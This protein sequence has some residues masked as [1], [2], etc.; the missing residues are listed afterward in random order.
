MI[1]CCSGQLAWS[2]SDLSRKFELE[3]EKGVPNESAEKE[4][5]ENILFVFVQH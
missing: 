3:R 1:L 4:M 5:K 2:D